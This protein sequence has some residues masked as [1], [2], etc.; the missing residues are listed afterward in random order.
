M[1]SKRKPSEALRKP[2]E[3]FFGLMCAALRSGIGSVC[4]S[5]I[6]V[7]AVIRLDPSYFDYIRFYTEKPSMIQSSFGLPRSGRIGREQNI[8]GE[9]GV[10]TGDACSICEAVFDRKSFRF[11]G[12]MR[13]NGSDF[14]PA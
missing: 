5:V 9:R 12:G 3:T 8:K 2:E 14:N 11:F 1:R 7:D 6:S 13:Y 10:N 4:S